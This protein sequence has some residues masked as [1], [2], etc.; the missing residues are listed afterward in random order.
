MNKVDLL[1]IIDL[2]VHSAPDVKPRS[3]DDFQLAEQAVRLGVELETLNAARQKLGGVVDE[4][5]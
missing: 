4:Q 5:S 2:H 3:H 1:G